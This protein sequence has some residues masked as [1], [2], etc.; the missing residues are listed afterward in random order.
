MHSGHIHETFCAEASLT[1]G[2]NMSQTPSDA[3]AISVQRT[4]EL[5]FVAR[6]R[7]VLELI[8]GPDGTLP[9]AVGPFDHVLIMVNSYRDDDASLQR[10]Y[11]F[12]PD[13][14][15]TL[16][17]QVMR[18]VWKSCDVGDYV[19]LPSKLRRTQFLVPMQ[20]GHR[21]SH[22]LRSISPFA[23]VSPSEYSGW[24]GK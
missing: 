24:V 22:S 17:P 11:I 10:F 8:R 6:H 4:I 21:L 9:L 19:E 14:L 13:D 16:C 1:N 3:N 7:R 23:L 20:G 2:S 18:A 12:G 15:S 5:P